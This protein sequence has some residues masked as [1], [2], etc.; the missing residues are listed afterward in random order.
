[1][2][3]CG[4]RISFTL[5]TEQSKFADWQKV[6]IQENANQVP[7][8]AM[9]RSMDVIF[10]NEA[11][12]RAKAGDKVVI[13]GVPIVV[14]DVGQLIGNKVQARR[15]AISGRG[16]DGFTQEGVTGLKSLG[17]RD[18]TYRLVFL[19]CFV[20][21]VEMKN[22]L[23]ALHDIIDEEDATERLLLQFSEEQLNELQEMKTD[24]RIYQKLANSICPHIY[25]HE[26]IKKGVLLQILGGVHKSTPEGIRLRG[27]VNVCIV[28]DP[29]TAKSQFLKYVTSFMPRAI[30]TSGKASSAAGLTAT[31]V[32][33]EETGEFT[34]EAG[35]LMLADN[36][37]CCID[38][39]DKMDLVDQVAIHEAMEQQTISI[40]K[41]GIQATLNAR[42]SIL[43]AANPIHGRY[44]K[45]LSLKVLFLISK[46]LPC[47]RP[48]CPDLISSLSF[49]TSVTSKRISALRSILSTFTVSR[50]KESILTT[51]LS[52]CSDT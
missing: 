51:R 8:G 44:D 45:K 33:D 13:T 50:R 41:A 26:D 19:G 30:Y 12:E 1:V 15:D 42:T 36:G 17:V 25:G 48:S 14:P 46:T 6:R 22:A 40:A 18:L 43:A 9:P 23:N 11:V 29:S 38:E 28:G 31:V 4:N 10:R 47:L 21:N 7:S 34:I 27:D 35:A 2:E 20:K 39:F 52:S 5:L 37:I 3:E 49:L 16:R 24:R 32:K